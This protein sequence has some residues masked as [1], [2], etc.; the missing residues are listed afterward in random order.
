MARHDI[1]N[2][3][4]IGTTGAAPESA[5]ERRRTERSLGVRQALAQVKDGQTIPAEDV[6]AWIESWDTPQELPMPRPRR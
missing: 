5:E 1:D 3:G 2:F 4:R 6:E